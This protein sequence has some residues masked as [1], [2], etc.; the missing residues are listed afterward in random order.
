M[1][2][3]QALQVKL[4]DFGESRQ[5]KSE[6][7]MTTVGSPFWMAP[8]VFM[9]MHYGP[10]CDVYS[11]SIVMLEIAYNGDINSIFAETDGDAAET[12]PSKTPFSVTPGSTMQRKATEAKQAPT[13]KIG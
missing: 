13:K 10:G 11:F 3:N 1:L 7:T 6:G 12:P 9:G 8:E 4:C 5:V 2:V